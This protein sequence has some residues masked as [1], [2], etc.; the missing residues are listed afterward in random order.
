MKSRRKFHLACLLFGVVNYKAPVYLHE[1][2]MGSSENRQRASR[3]GSS[4]LHIP[5][6]R[7]EAFRGSFRYAASKCWN[8]IPPPIKRLKGVCSFRVRL[9]RYLIDE[10]IE[11]GDIN[12]DFSFIWCEVLV[13][14][15][16]LVCLYILFWYCLCTFIS[17]DNI[18]N[19]VYF[20]SYVCIMYGISLL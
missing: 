10:Q 20:Y 8:N 1:K 16:D 15:F 19:F 14:L 11:Y 3:H 6:H 13:F 7:T 5:R 18:F 9:K 12:C 2:L 17:S 4:Q